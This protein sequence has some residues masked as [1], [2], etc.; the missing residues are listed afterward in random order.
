MERQID[1]PECG[2]DCT[3][4]LPET[5][6]ERFCSDCP[7]VWDIRSAEEIAAEQI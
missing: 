3:F 6:W 7:A 2:S 4:P 1:C 5:M